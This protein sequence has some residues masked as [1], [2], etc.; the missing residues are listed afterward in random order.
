MIVPGAFAA[1]SGDPPVRGQ[2]PHSFVR[3]DRIILPLRLGVS[4]E[5]TVYGTTIDQ[6]LRP[7]CT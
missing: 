7:G 5:R 4:S 2:A 1:T 6:A 3:S